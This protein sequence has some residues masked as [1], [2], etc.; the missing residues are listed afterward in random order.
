MEPP[1]D[2][3]LF[4]P[5]QWKISI[6]I[7]SVPELTHCGAGAVFQLKDREKEEYNE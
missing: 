7:K 4:M 1:A 5:N 3:V 6:G 2:D